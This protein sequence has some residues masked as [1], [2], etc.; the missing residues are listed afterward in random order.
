MLDNPMDVAP[1]D[2]AS[3]VGL[4]AKFADAQRRFDA[5]AEQFT[6]LAAAIRDAWP[7]R[8]R[9]TSQEAALRKYVGDFERV[10][11][12]MRSLS[13]LSFDNLREGNA[14]LTACIAQLEEL[15][16]T[17]QRHDT[18][19]GSRGGDRGGRTTPP[20][21][22]EREEALRFFG[23]SIASPPKTAQELKS[24]WRSKLKLLHPDAHPGASDDKKKRMNEDTAI[25]NRYYNEL[26][27]R[28]SWS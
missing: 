3:A 6:T 15:L 2:A 17:A 5:L 11:E 13:D 16:E 19:G 7:D 26:R 12:R 1:A 24:A 10:A 9:A 4:V 25:C 14:F 20:P 21:P 28:F 27:V 8:W 23:F 22:D 18:S